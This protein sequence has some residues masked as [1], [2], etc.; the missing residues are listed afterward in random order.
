ME[1][2]LVVFILIFILLS[3]IAAS[4]YANVIWILF[5]VLGPIIGAVLWKK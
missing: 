4:E 5:I 1:K 3:I 2:G